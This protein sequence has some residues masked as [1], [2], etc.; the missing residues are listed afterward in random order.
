MLASPGSFAEAPTLEHLHPAGAGR[1][2]TNSVAIAGKVDPWPAIAWVEGAGVTFTAETN[3]NRFRVEVAADALPGP[4]LVRLFNDEGASEPR[5]FVVGDSHEVAEVE[6]NNSFSAPQRIA[7]VPVTINGRLDKTGDVDS[8]AVS[9]RAGQWLEARFDAYVLMSKLDGVLKLVDPEGRQLAWNHDDATLDPRLV[10]QA[11]SDRTVVVQAFGFRYP[12]DSSI[13]LGGGES[14]VYRLH[15]AVTDRPPDPFACSDAEIGVSGSAARSLPFR[16]IGNLARGEDVTRVSFLAPTNGFVVAEVWAGSLGSPLD[17]WLAIEDAAGKELAR[18]DDTEGSRDPRLEWQPPA[19]TNRVFVAAV[20]SVTH[21]G[22]PD[23]RYR[24]EVRGAGPDFE[25]TTD[26]AAYTVMAGATNTVK[27]KVRRMRGQAGELGASWRGLPAGVEAPAR[28]LKSGESEA[29][30]SLVAAT[31][32]V[33]FNGP[34]QLVV[35]DAA[36]GTERIA[37]FELVSR[38]ENN[39]V[40]QGFGRLLIERVDPLWL[41]VRSNPPPAAPTPAAA[42]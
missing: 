40:P 33:P 37:G 2:S 20:G 15:L 16:R 6:P 32:A 36:T 27:L 42:K 8:F 25:A 34:V 21:R 9:L 10:W 19:G 23:S 11:P 31:N 17:A 18:N 35:R 26:A 22:G 24:L 30:M 39:G 4:R 14:A 5:F 38:G 7:T 28:T 29:A 12:A 1:G 41:T 3:K 13:V